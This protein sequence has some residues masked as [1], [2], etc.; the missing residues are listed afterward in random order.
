MSTITLHLSF[1]TGNTHKFQEVKVFI[2]KFKTTRDINLK[3]ILISLG[4]ID[5]FCWNADFSGMEPKKELYITD[6][7]HKAFIKVDEAGTEAVAATAIAISVTS[8]LPMRE[9]PVFRADHPFIFLIR[10][11]TT[12]CILFLGRL[13]SPRD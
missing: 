8:A 13:T 2:P 5:A 1:L 7:V 3:E 4:M 6:A 9:A 11:N 10:E 12:K